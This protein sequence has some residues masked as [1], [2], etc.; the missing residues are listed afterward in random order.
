MEDRIK[1]LKYCSKVV[2][3]ICILFIIVD[4][5]D[6]AFVGALI[7]FLFGAGLLVPIFAG[8][9][10]LK[11][12]FLCLYFSI[13]LNIVVCVVTMLESDYIACIP[14]FICSGTISA[15]F[16]D[17]RLMK[18]SFASSIF[19]FLLEMTVLSL[20]S[21]GFI[22]EPF[23]IAECVLGM[24]TSFFLIH[25]CVS[26]GLRYMAR[27]D[28]NEAK[29][30]ELLHTVNAQIEEVQTASDKSRHILE[31]VHQ[32]SADILDGADSLTAGSAS[33]ASGAAQQSELVTELEETIQTVSSK[34]RE[35]AEYAGKVRKEAEEMSVNVDAG[36]RKMEDLLNAVQE[37]YDSS[38]AIEKINKEIEDIAFQTNILALNAAIEAASAGAAGKGF[39]VVAEQV[40]NLAAKSTQAAGSTSGLI[41]SCLS[42]V[43]HGSEIASETAS[44]LEQIGNSVNEV[45]SKTYMISDMTND[46]ASMVGEIN[47]K[48]NQVSDVIQSIADTARETQA[49]GLDFQK[50]AEMLENLCETI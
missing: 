50:H 25:S 15:I 35:T 34:I 27:S 31:E 49:A 41:E 10:R 43:S 1:L 45:S 12:S 8:I 29:S 44:A 40:R 7:L 4:L 5:V 16:F 36:N 17:T 9:N 11:E 3:I 32:A 18:I 13:G 48:I 30:Q 20:L 39:A 24:L 38:K 14:L 19:L 46:Q 37:I 6:G 21:G 23:V 42:A 22:I 26:N 28:A 47:Q 2:G 33:L